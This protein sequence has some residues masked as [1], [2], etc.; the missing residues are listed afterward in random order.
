MSAT[1]LADEA[2]ALAS[3]LDG[4]EGG[5]TL[6]VG[7]LAATGDRERL[8]RARQVLVRRIYERSD[9]HEATAAL[10][11]VNKAL[12]VIGWHDPYSWKHR[13]KP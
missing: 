9:D 2:L 6:A 3:S 12:A 1:D 10:T 13:R 8:E 11:L 5:L 4:G 7:Q